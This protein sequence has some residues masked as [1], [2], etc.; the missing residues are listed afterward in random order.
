MIWRVSSRSSS[1][2][3][4]DMEARLEVLHVR[5]EGAVVERIGAKD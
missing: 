4:A 3:V 1:D 2:E 5:E